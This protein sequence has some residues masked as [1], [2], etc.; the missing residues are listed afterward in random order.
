M[1]LDVLELLSLPKPSCILE[2]ESLFGGWK[3]DNR[4][5]LNYGDLKVSLLLLFSSTNW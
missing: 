5:S 3:I 2:V 4:E 1:A